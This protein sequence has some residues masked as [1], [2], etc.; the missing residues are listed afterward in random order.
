MRLL[1]LNR[2][3]WPDLE[4]TGQNLTELCQALS[5]RFRITVV[6]GPSY[7]VETNRRGPWSRQQ[8]GDITI[9]RTWGTRFAKRRL[10]GRLTN[11]GTYFVLAAFA[12]FSTSKPDI[13]IAA[14]DPPL[15]GALGVLLSK[16]WRC[17]FVYNVRDLYPDVAEANGGIK[18]KFLLGLLKWANDFAYAGA[19]TV[20]VLGED[21]R[22]L[23]ISKGVPAEKVKVVPNFVD[24]A[25]VHPIEPNPLRSQF[26]G[27]FVV[28]YSGNLGLSQQLETVLDAASRLRDDQIL[29]LLVG[30]GARKKW[31]QQRAEALGLRN[32]EFRPYQPKDR[33]A[34][35]LSAADIHLI[36][37]LKA[38]TGAI[39]PS[40]IYGILAAGRPYVAMMDE[41]AEAAR[42]VREYSIGFVVPPGDAQALADTIRHAADQPEDLI[43]KGQRARRL[44]QEQFDRDIITRKYSEVLEAL[45]PASPQSGVGDPTTVG[46]PHS[47]GRAQ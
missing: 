3:F 10:V 45:G 38:A 25:K 44:A 19:D 34:E 9:V 1:L 41:A 35:S 37:L 32:V 12:A 40:K 2:S 11:L 47:H 14:T 15:L 5:S 31:L 24:C 36:P 27:K 16:W 20:I 42:L 29:F 13:V 18:S 7:H 23:V 22:R 30:E 43:S 33:L 26:P 6:A 46:Y 21:M 4:S 39:V 17:S 8:L 28:M